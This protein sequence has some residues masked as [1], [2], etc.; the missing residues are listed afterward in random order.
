MAMQVQFYQKTGCGGN[1][2][3]LNWLREAGIDPEVLDLA[4]TRWTAEQLTPFLAGMKVADWFNG[5]APAVRDGLVKPD[6]LSA[7]EALALIIERPLL[8]KRPLIRAEADHQSEPLYL[9]GFDL[10]RLLAWLNLDNGIIERM[11]ENPGSCQKGAG[12]MGC[13]GHHAEADV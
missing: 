3:Q 12:H 10:P 9:C 5:S 6:Q 1:R 8:V 4:S 13:S 11:P 2:K 7:E